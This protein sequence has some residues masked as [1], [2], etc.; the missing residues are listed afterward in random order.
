MQD[1]V[2]GVEEVEEEVE[3]DGVAQEVAREVVQN[4]EVQNRGTQN[5]SGQVV[6]R[7]RKYLYC[8]L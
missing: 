4:L 1:G 7:I 5:N 3:V 2:E 6:L 8:I